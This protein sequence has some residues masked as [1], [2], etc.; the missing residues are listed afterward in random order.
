MT[1]NDLGDM[2]RV[3]GHHIPTQGVNSTRKPMFKSVLNGFVQKR[4]LSFFSHSLIWDR[5]QNWPDLR[6]PISKFPDICFIDTVT[7]INRW[8]FQGN[9]SVG[10]AL[11]S[12]Q[13]FYEVKQASIQL[14]DESN[15]ICHLTSLTESLTH[16]WHHRTKSS[17]SA[18]CAYLAIVWP[19]YSHGLY[20]IGSWFAHATVHWEGTKPM[21]KPPWE[22]PLADLTS[23]TDSPL[24]HHASAYDMLCDIFYL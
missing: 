7:D 6:S 15:A 1:W 3:T 5:S 14:F 18:V 21:Y 8:K 17:P 13:L 23:Y 10:V 20:Y 16:A 2:T 24:S 22:V 12:I 19:L 11:T 9:R 4:R